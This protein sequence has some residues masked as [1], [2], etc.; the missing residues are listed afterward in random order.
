MNLEEIREWFVRDSG[1]YDLVEDSTDWADNGAD[2]Y[3]QAGQ[4]WLDKQVVMSSQ[5]GKFFRTLSADS[6]VLTLTGLRSV[7]SVYMRESDDDTTR[8]TYKTYDELRG[9]FGEDFSTISSGNPL[10]YSILNYRQHDEADSDP[11][12]EEGLTDADWMTTDGLLI[13]PPPSEDI[14]VVVEGKFSH[15]ELS[16]DADENFWSVNE[17]SVLVKAALRELEIF[18]RNTAGVND[19]TNALIQDLIGI[20]KDYIELTYSHITKLEG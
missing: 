11:P 14:V 10:Y 4:R 1:R 13:L 15:T 5:Y 2:K 19:W 18:Y 12:D 20:E 17:P 3:I 9:L 7:V 8:L 16:D 6:R